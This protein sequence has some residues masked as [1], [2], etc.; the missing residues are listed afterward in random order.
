MRSLDKDLECVILHVLSEK[1]ECSM[2]NQVFFWR[3]FQGLVLL[4]GRRVCEFLFP[5]VLGSEGQKLAVLQVLR[6][7]HTIPK[8]VLVCACK[9]VSTESK[10]K[11]SL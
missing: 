8:L 7:Y 3:V 5:E 1:G 9:C 10:K 11:G 2:H 6:Q 4:R